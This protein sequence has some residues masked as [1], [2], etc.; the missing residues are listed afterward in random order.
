[1]LFTLLILIG[2]VVTTTSFKAFDYNA[3]FEY[4]VGAEIQSVEFSFPAITGPENRTLVTE[5]AM[6]PWFD[7]PGWMRRQ[8]APSKLYT[9]NWSRNAEIIFYSCSNII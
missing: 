4:P 7:T 1:M 9:I 2:F 8:D 5:G 3:T 6:K